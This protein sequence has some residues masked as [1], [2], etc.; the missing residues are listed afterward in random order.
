MTA[1]FDTNILVYACDKKEPRRTLE[2]RTLLAD[3]EDGVLLWQVAFWDAMIYA[4]CL[5]A[6]VE[7]IYSEDLPGCPVTGLEVVNP[8]NSKS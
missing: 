6:G 7:R 8:F 4:A 3:C 2:A 5:E 1:A